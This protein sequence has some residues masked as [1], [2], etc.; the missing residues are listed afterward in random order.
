L[1]PGSHA[2]QACILIQSS[3]E[4]PKIHGF[5]L[6]L[7]D[8]PAYADYNERIL[9]TLEQMLANGLKKHTRR[10]VFYTLRDLNRHVDLMNPEAVKL[11]LATLKKEN[12]E[13]ASEATKQK[14]ANNYFAVSNGLTWNKP[15]YKYDSKV[16]I[17][18][19]KEQAEAIISSAPTT[20]TATIF[21]IL[22]ESG[23]EGEE[24]HQTTA[25]DI[26]TEQGIQLTRV[27]KLYLR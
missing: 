13:P 3:K 18:P 12:G 2:P 9:K 26:D 19:T 16:P 23:F 20:N 6:L 15:I 27:L 14:K 10:Q 17:T 25:K 22:L 1:N 7:D 24:L 5:A 4:F 11:H 8:G 21:R